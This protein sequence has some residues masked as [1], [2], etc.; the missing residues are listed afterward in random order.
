M[1]EKDGLPKDQP[2]LQACMATCISADDM[3]MEEYVKTNQGLLQWVFTFIIKQWSAWDEFLSSDKHI[4]MKAGKAV[5]SLRTIVTWAWI[6]NGEHEHSDDEIVIQ[7]QID[8]FVQLVL[9][10]YQGW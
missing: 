1:D 9:P 2:M 4:L 6:C 7:G 10:A 8:W 5:T 3:S